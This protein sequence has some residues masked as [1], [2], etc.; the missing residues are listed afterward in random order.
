MSFG[1][2]QAFASF[3][4][5]AAS[6]G[7]EIAKSQREYD[8]E[9]AAKAADLERQENFAR[10]QYD[11]QAP[12]REIENS[13]KDRQL[14]ATEM[15][16]ET[17]KMN[18]ESNAEY[19]KQQ[20]K[21]QAERDKVNMAQFSGQYGK[22]ASGNIIKLSKADLASGRFKPVSDEE[23]AKHMN[24]V[25][26][27]ASHDALLKKIDKRSED[28]LKQGW[29]PEDVEVAKKQAI[30]LGIDDPKKAMDIYRSIPGLTPKMVAEASKLADAAIENGE[31]V[32]YI[33][34]G[35]KYKKKAEDI[36]RA[37]LVKIMAAK[38]MKGAT[39]PLP[40]QIEEQR[41]LEEEQQKQQ[42][43]VPTGKQELQVGQMGTL[44]DMLPDWFVEMKRGL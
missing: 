18:A 17:N 38:T 43:A 32:A 7:A 28:L 2:A 34:N 11:L 6:R 35:K 5:G 15:N 33:E 27:D 21:L 14:S 30:I 26:I 13:Y 40:S 4:G 25:K 39:R 8:Q 31:K 24:K 1:L 16:A 23:L 3:T 9:Q 12:Q 10:F 44:D 20:E 29:K 19:H 22:D 41:Q 42:Q 36:P 37:K